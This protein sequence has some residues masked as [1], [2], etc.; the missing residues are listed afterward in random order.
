MYNNDETTKR[1]TS[2]KHNKIMPR[3]WWAA[4]QKV[5][6]DQIRTH[7]ENG[8]AAAAEVAVKM[9][10]AYPIWAGVVTNSWIWLS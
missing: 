10:C 5:Q 7:K 4:W 3:E 2:L 1:A 6:K 8:Q 9:G